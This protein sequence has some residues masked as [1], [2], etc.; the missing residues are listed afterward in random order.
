MAMNP[1][2]DLTTQWIGARVLRAEDDRFLRGQATYVE[3][4][5][6]PELGDA[7]HVVFVRSTMAHAELVSVSVTEA[8]AAAGVV[9]VITAQ[10]H[11]VVPVGAFAPEYPVAFAQP[12][13]AERRVRYVG[14]P[15]SLIHI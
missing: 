4:L 8:A 13:L 5:Q 11:D 6:L 15:L 1:T 7:V 10:D 14:E 2:D 12:L 9:K 3:D